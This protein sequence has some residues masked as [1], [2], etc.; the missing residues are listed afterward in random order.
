MKFGKRVSFGGATVAGRFGIKEST[1]GI[2]GDLYLFDDRLVLSVDVFDTQ[3]TNQYPRVKATLADAIWKRNLFLVGGAD[4]IAQLPRARRAGAGGGFDWF[5]GAPAA[6]STTRI[7]KSLLLSAAAPRRA[8]PSS[9]RKSAREA[10]RRGPGRAAP[11]GR[12]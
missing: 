2:G 11:R 6:S 4:D 1:G 12:A 7:S 8:P 9:R 10:G 5:L 3:S